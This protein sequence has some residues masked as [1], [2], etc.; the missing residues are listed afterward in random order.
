MKIAILGLALT[1]VGQPLYAQP[2]SPNDKPKS[3][4]VN[5]SPLQK[6]EFSFLGVSPEAQV[7]SALIGGKDCAV[8]PVGKTECSAPYSSSLKIGNA[9][10]YVLELEFNN[11]KLYAVIGSVKSTAY[12][13]LMSAFSAKYGSP[14]ESKPEKWQSKAGAVFDNLVS[15]WHFKGGDL[16]VQA[17]GTSRDDTDFMF[18]HLGNAPAAVPT[19]VNF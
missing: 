12:S 5:H 6:P 17:M 9:P 3:T 7:S 11:G 1:V 16:V 14:A 2:H 13:D 19:P 10:I 8:N 18:S 4:I 15:T